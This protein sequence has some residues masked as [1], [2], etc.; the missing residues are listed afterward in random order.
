M[1]L[2]GFDLLNLTY[3]D[4]V[5][6]TRVCERS[7]GR[8]FE[9]RTFHGDTLGEFD[10]LSRDLAAIPPHVSRVAETGRL[11]DYAFIR[12]EPLPA[13]VSLRG[14]AAIVR[15]AGGDTPA[16]RIYRLALQLKLQR[17]SSQPQA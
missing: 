6:V 4:A 5:Q 9:I 11:D 14:W 1:D 16:E 10:R 15:A 8:T 2:T 17:R 3:E 12:T 13:G 7:T